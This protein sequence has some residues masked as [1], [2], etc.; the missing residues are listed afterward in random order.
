MQPDAICDIT[1][2]QLFFLTHVG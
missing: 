2:I 1:V